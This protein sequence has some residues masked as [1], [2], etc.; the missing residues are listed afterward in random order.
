MSG[1]R[2]YVI[3]GGKPAFLRELSRDSIPL[4]AAPAS[5]FI[6]SS[7]IPLAI[8][9]LSV[10]RLAFP[11]YV[12]DMLST[13]SE[14][15]PDASRSLFDSVAAEIAVRPSLPVVSLAAL[16]ALWSASRGLSAILRGILRVYSSPEAARDFRRGVRSLV[17]T[18]AFT[19]L[20]A[21]SLVLLVFGKYLRS[22]SSPAL[23]EAPIFLRYREVLLFFILALNF[24]LLY[25][26]AASGG[27]FSRMVKK[28]DGRERLSRHL[29][30]GAGA[31]AG[32]IVFSK[33]YSLYFEKFGTFSRLYGSLAAI[34]FFMLW[35][36]F[37]VTI[38]LLG[39][40]VNKMMA[41]S[42][43]ASS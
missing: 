35:V 8:L 18:A 25:Y 33:L 12:D 36:Y 29:P 30:G 7:A 41:R 13:V 21:L 24:S 11:A 42:P 3:S 19:V 9:I 6:C 16:S 32:W 14:L 37:C 17:Y 34:T 10:S 39:A 4:Y 31:A 40:E 26:F 27:S 15:I 5:F 1:K 20:M 2:S 23:G 43:R 28:G 38:L 22:V